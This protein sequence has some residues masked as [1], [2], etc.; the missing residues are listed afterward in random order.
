MTTTTTTTTMAKTTTTT[1]AKTQVKENEEKNE[2]IMTIDGCQISGKPDIW[3]AR[4]LANLPDL[5]SVSGLA[6][7]GY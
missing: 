2:H 3:Q 7:P 6:S 4:Y 5:A 1:M